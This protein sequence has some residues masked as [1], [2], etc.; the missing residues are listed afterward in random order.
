MELG[1]EQLVRIMGCTWL[2]AQRF[3]PGLAAAMAEFGI[4]TPARVAAFLAQVGHESGGLRYVAEIASG[5]VYNDRKNLGNT[6]P[7]AVAIAARYGNTP[8]PFWKGRGLIQ[9]TGYD[10]YLACGAALGLD[11]VHRPALLEQP[12]YACRSAAWFWR[13]HGLNAQADAGD[14]DGVSDIINRGRKTAAQ[15]D[16]RGFADR[17]ARW[18]IAK[19]VLAA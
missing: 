13:E 6:R 9:L 7:E 17:L 2:R 18:E 15:G 12:E 5:L 19:E 11:L 4:D 1:I 10:N 3:A 8:G 14:F 16:A